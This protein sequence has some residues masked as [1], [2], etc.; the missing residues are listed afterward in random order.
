[1]QVQRSSNTFFESGIDGVTAKVKKSVRDDIQ[2][3]LDGGF[4]VET[5]N[6]YDEF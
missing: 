2:N 6:E 3:P 1:M 5:N 4:E